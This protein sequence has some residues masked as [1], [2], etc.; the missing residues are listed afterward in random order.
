MYKAVGKMA[1]NYTSKVCLHILSTDAIFSSNTQ[2][3]LYLIK[4]V[5][6]VRIKN[7]GT[8]I[9]IQKLESVQIILSSYQ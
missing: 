8:A 7:K 4:D 2:T 5:K 6:F 1:L 9:G 3:K